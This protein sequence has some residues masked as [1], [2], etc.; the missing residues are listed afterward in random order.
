MTRTITTIACILSL[1]AFCATTAKAEPG[2]LDPG[3]FI[4]GN[5]FCSQTYGTVEAWSP[6]MRA[7]TSDETVAFVDVLLRWNGSS[8][9]PYQASPGF[10]KTQSYNIFVEG[11]DP[12]LNR[13][14]LNGRIVNGDWTFRNLPHGYYA[15]RQMMRWGGIRSIPPKTR[16]TLATIGFN[17]N[18]TYCR[19]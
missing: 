10:A 18:A 3:G 11:T 4:P 1:A 9:Q 8:W 19:I 7:Q 6:F 16:N 14:Y 17:A 13:W 12:A 15:V 5:L 2:P